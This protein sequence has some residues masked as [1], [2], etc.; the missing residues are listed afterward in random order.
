MP[1][2]LA[3]LSRELSRPYYEDAFPAHDI[4][5]AKRVRDVALRLATQHPDGVNRDVL[6][7]AAW[8]HD[9]G[10]PLERIGE[11]D[12]HDEWAADEATNLLA[13]EGVASDRIAAVEHCL[14]AHSIRTSSPDPET[15][16]A[17]LLF[18]ADKLD[19]TGVIGLVR[20]ACIVGER[21]G[22]VGEQY[23]IIDDAATLTD[24]APELPDVDLLRE[25]ARERLDALYTESGRCL[26]ESRWDVMEDFFDRF[27]REIDP[28]TT[29]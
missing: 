10:R 9:I 24:G 23:A 2:N 19:A 12:D 4:F 27:A 28:D 18:D 6:A 29:Q 25:W 8:L 17:Q 22:R 3:P 1:S 13:A 26:G 21:S 11:I 15:L 5:H 16:E 7:A 20:L 14:R